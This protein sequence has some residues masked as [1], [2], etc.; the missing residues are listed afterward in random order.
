MADVFISYARSTESCARALAEAIESEGHS[1]WYDARLPAHRTYGD[2]IQEQIDAAKAVLIIWSNEAARSQWV[3]SEADRGRHN[4]TLVQVRI[5]DCKLP[6][7]FDQIQC[8]LL[9]EW[10]GDSSNPAYHVVRDTLSELLNGESAAVEPKLRKTRSGEAQLLLDTAI[11][12][13]Q[14]G[15]PH[16][17]AQAISLLVEATS[18][19]P[20]DAEVWG[21]LAVLYAARRSEVA[22]AERPALLV[23][24]R[25][26]IKT[27]LKLD[28]EEIRARCAEVILIRPYR[29]WARKEQWASAVLQRV[30]T[31]PLALFSLATVLAEAGR[32]E[33]AA[34]CARQID[35][36]RFLLPAV[37]QFTVQ[38]LWAA[39]D[40][41]QAELSGVQAARRF[42][43]HLGL[44]DARL[45]LLMYSGRTSDAE[46]MIQGFRN[47]D[48]PGAKL[49]AAQITARALAGDGV[50]EAI[51]HNLGAML[52]GTVEPLTAAMRCSALG[53]VEEC[54]AVLDGYFFA[55]GRFASIAPPGGDEDRSTA[56]LF[57]PPMEA[58]WKDA[59][60]AALTQAIGLSDY[61]SRSCS[62]PVWLPHQ[63]N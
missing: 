47:G 4:G 28:P 7:P 16:E 49:D 55:K 15:Q 8:P 32:W 14:S 10:S 5:D 44:F 46:M 35:R 62:T 57:L 21:M 45:A 3:R 9:E 24:A 26:A 37:E 36:K 53:S 42:P 1:V 51:E 38:S 48:Y 29:N 61:W 39:G 11:K 63:E 18:I 52:R 31:Q 2:V 58:V 41:V 33:E 23:R 60:F 43:A 27:A 54:F 22:L 19:A 25:S 34:E 6:M 50:R 17:H 30:P 20:N 56:T 13:L 59:R 40:L 12:C